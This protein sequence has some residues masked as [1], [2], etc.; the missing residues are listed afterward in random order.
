MTASLKVRNGIWQIVFSYKDET[1]KWKQKSESTRLKEKGNKRK[2][3]QMMRDRLQELNASSKKLEMQK[4]RVTFLDAMEEWLHKVMTTQVRPNTWDEYRRVFEYHIKPYPDFQNL[5][6]S[7]LTPKLLQDYYN[8][9]TASGLSPNTIHKQHANIGKFLKYAV[10]LDMIPYSPAERVVLPKKTKS[11]AANYY[12]A[13]ELQALMRLFWNDPL[14]DVVFLTAHLGLRRSEI[15]GLR[16]DAVDFQR[17]QILI[18]HTAVVSNGERIYSDHTKSEASRRTLPMSKAVSD[19]LTHMK[20]KQE[21][22]MSRLGAIYNDSGYVCV[23]EDGR[24]IDPSF[25][26]KHFK[27]VVKASELRNI[28]FHD[29]RHSV[30]TLLH[31]GGCDLKDIQSWLGHSDI[32]TT[33]NIY[34]HMDSRRM[35]SMADAMEQALAPKLKIG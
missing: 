5:L 4:N 23:K 1:G 29:L 28:R 25:V 13:E 18:R 14:E 9:K 2:A 20:S 12:T 22:V 30:A 32:Q 35:G 26:T 17:G 15:C 31:S 33:S 7:D 19:Y 10:Q 21:R 34:T 3:E 24:P 8:T 16:W 27:L 6:L 11:T